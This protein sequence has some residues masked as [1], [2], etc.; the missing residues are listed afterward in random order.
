MIPFS[1]ALRVL[2]FR[3]DRKLLLGLNRNH[4]WLGLAGTWLAGIGRYYDS[5]TASGLQQ[6]GIGSVIYIFVLSA[7]IWLL[8]KPYRIHGLTY[9]RLLTFI[10]LV[11]FPA[12][13]YAIPVERMTDLNHASRINA[14]FL[15][16]VATYRVAL[17][18]R[19][20]RRMTD[21]SREYAIGLTL[22]PIITIIVA[23]TFLNLEKAVFNLMGGLQTSNDGAY[24]IL[25]GL[26]VVSALL[27]LPL[28]ALYAA[29]I[30]R[31]RN[32]P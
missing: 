23:L 4:F 9:F 22:L 11:S 10:S 30:F 1:D 27:L 14:W 2:T 18:Y 29:G 26:T 16:I 25:T 31:A 28:L 8:S 15:L 24:A 13:L 20:F 21:F 3:F 7:F 5:P 12:L 17:L 32:N 6:T 19:F